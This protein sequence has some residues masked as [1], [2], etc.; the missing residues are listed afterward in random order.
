[1]AVLQALLLIAYPLLVY[2]ALG[3]APP[4]A[5]ALCTLALLAARAALGSRARLAALL[6]VFAPVGAAFAAASL[7]SLFSN[8]PLWLLLAPALLNAA[9]LAVF[10]SS[11][12]RRQS[13]IEI[14]A[15]A[16]V[17]TLSEGEV[18][19]CRRVTLVWCV[20]FAANGAL[21]AALALAG[22]REAWAL[23]T[24]L[25]AYLLMGLLFACEY[26][27]RHWRFRRYVGGPVDPVLRRLFPPD[28]RGR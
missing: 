3:F 4:R 13:A 14:L 25:A 11:L 8:D 21:C 15:R 20:F 6:R 16:Q 9:L 23:Y 28:A 26:V 1:M 7:V 18:T 5:I 2:V 12:W 27:Y 19:Y 24:G 17:G 22:S 10:A